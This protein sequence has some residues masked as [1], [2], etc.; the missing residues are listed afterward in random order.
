MPP[1]E[2]LTLLRERLTKL[3]K[4]KRLQQLREL[5]EHGNTPLLLAITLEYPNVASLLLQC[6]ETDPMHAN[7]EGDTALS[8]AA[9]TKRPFVVSAVLHRLLSVDRLERGE[10]VTFPV[11]SQP[12]CCLHSPMNR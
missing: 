12:N 6:Q 10:L 7:A 3:D 8:L 2:A 5:D 1:Q 4:S 9:R 11:L